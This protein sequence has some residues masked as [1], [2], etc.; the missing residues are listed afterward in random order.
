MKHAVESMLQQAATIHISC[1]QQTSLIEDIVQLLIDAYRQGRKVLLFGNGGSAAQAQH[2]VAEL[3]N[4]MVLDRRALP[5]IALNT[6]SSI[7]TCVANDLDYS[8]IFSRQIEAL[9]TSGD[10]AWGLS[11]SGNSPNVLLAIG[12]ARKMG[13]KTIGFTGL[14]GKKLASV[15]DYCLMVPSEFT[16]RIQEVHIT[17]GHII[18]ELLERELFGK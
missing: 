10:V 17:V 9:G 11:T 15:V 4:R 14:K 2:I 7:I 13:L 6:D 16:P 5:A 12:T 3:V 18:C 8:Q 1:I